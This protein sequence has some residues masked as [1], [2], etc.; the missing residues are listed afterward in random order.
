MIGRIWRRW[1]RGKGGNGGGSTMAPVDQANMRD[2]RATDRGKWAQPILGTLVTVGF[3]F[4]LCFLFMQKDDGT[5]GMREAR[6]IMLGALQAAFGMVV[7]YYFGS[8]KGSSDKDYLLANSTPLPIRSP[9]S[10]TTTVTAAN[11]VPPGAPTTTTTVVSGEQPDTSGASEANAP[12]L[13]DP[14]R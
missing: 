12:P 13:P 7:A 2:R 8:S 5:N 10:V 1:R 3:F 4:V 9:Q 11:P 6:L 14:Q